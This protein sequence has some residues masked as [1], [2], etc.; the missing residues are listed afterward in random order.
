LSSVAFAQ[1]SSSRGRGCGCGE[2][3]RL[4]P[5][6]G[7]G[8]PRAVAAK[9]WWYLG[10]DDTLHLFTPL[11]RAL[12]C[13]SM[14]RN[15]CETHERIVSP[16]SSMEASPDSCHRHVARPENLT[17][18]PR[19]RST[20]FQSCHRTFNSVAP[21]S[22]CPFRCA[23]TPCAP[24]RIVCATCVGMRF[25][26]ALAFWQLMGCVTDPSEGRPT[27]PK[28][29][30]PASAGP[31]PPHRAVTGSPSAP[32]APRAGPASLPDQ[33]VV[34]RYARRGTVIYFS[35]SPVPPLP[36]TDA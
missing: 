32:G 23:P 24:C 31:A 15:W 22:G 3:R 14:R 30:H 16:L 4:L 17:D 10:P 1:F 8:R 21:P 35:G 18:R 33:P 25:N 2:N 27:L 7:N 36:A 13:V 12:P 29:P 6:S 20:H 19:R 11:S 26:D 9:N 34:T 5:D 28:G